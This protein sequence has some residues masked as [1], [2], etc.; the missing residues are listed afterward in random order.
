MQEKKYNVQTFRE[1]YCQTCSNWFIA[2]EMCIRNWHAFAFPWPNDREAYDVMITGHKR[3][4][5]I[6]RYENAYA[7]VD[8]EL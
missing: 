2:S 6:F 4:V 5:G 1:R 8:A 3:C 7:N